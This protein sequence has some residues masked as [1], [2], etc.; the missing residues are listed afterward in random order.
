MGG[1]ELY[2]FS[3]ALTVEMDPAWRTPI[4][5]LAFVYQAK[6]DL[7]KSLEYWD[8]IRQTVNQPGKGI[9]GYVIALGILHN[10][11]EHHHWIEQLEHRAEN[12]TAVD[13]D[14][15]L[16]NGYAAIGN[17]DKAFYHLNRCYENRAGSIMFCIRY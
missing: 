1:G 3:T 14:S 12:D 6:G 4:E 9:S 7:Q 8:Y 15:E 11:E 10:K 16:A 5:K 13:L 17:M 2:N